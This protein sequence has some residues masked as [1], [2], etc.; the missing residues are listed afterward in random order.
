[1]HNHLK[2]WNFITSDAGSKEEKITLLNYVPKAKLAFLGVLHVTLDNNNN[3]SN[4]SKS[5]II[6]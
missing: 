5:C 6:K 3:N 1:M 2:A 4:N